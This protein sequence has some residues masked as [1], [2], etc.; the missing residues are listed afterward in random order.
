MIYKLIREEL[1]DCQTVLSE[2]SK[3]L[4]SEAF[5]LHSSLR[6]YT[7]NQEGLE[8]LLAVCFRLHLWHVEVPRQGLNP[9]HSSDLSCCSDKDG[10]LTH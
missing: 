7:D 3:D 10:S 1:C 4:G 5:V 8:I 6:N 2:T 9:C